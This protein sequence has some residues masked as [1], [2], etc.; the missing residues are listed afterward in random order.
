MSVVTI[1]DVLKAMVEDNDDNNDCIH[2]DDIRN[3]QA[4]MNILNSPA[5][6]IQKLHRNPD[7]KYV[8]SSFL[9]CVASEVFEVMEWSVI[10]YR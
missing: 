3:L 4:D 9:G 10:L 7:Q 1:P 6:F 8:T 2:R 5:F